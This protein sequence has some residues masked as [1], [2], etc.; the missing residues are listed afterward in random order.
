MRTQPAHRYAR[1][2]L[3][4]RVACGECSRVAQAVAIVIISF[5]HP[6]IHKASLPAEHRDPGDDLVLG[7]M[8]NELS[9]SMGRGAVLLYITVR[10]NMLKAVP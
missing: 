7:A 5:C 10:E 8:R 1:V 4:L 6:L 3:W 2:H 9:T